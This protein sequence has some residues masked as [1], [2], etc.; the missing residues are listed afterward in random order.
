MKIL[1]A[2]TEALPF[3]ST[4][5]LADVIGSLP[6][7]VKKEMWKTSD[8]RVVIPLYPSV[9]E[10]FSEQM[11]L[12]CE[13][14]VRLAWRN[15]YCGIWKIESEGVIFYFIDNLYYFERNML[16]GSYDDAER[17]AFFSKCVLELMSALNFYPDILHANDWQSA[18]SV[19][20]LKRKY[21]HIEEYKKISALFT[22]HNIDYQGVF[23]FNILNDVFELPEW[24]RSIVEYNG[25]INLLKGAIQCADM[26][27]T[28]SRTY[29]REILTDFYASGLQHI[30]R[31]SEA[32][33]KL[34]GIV[35]G[36]DVD[37][38]NPENRL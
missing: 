18:L 30:L 24:D 29:A 12:V 27:S 37:Y 38:Y 15:Q 1:Y 11:E 4:G 2:A 21:S 22:I 8:V 6:K 5:G 9:R 14:S 26:V 31:K 3:V 17:F 19:I 34:V 7:A 35:N 36:I 16:Y 10:K 20:Y 28:V 23:D 13:I 33:G 32:E 25:C